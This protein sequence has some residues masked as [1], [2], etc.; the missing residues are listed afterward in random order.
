MIIQARESVK[1]SSIQD[2]QITTTKHIKVKALSL[3]NTE[4]ML[5]TAREK[6][7]VTFKGKPIR[8]TD[9]S[10]ESLKQKNAWNGIFK[11]PERK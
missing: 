6:S 7:Q 10:T 4:T 11:S 5:K 2:Q 9:F 8:I 3:Q 1:T